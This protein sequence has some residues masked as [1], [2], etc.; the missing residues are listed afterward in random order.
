MAYVLADT[1]PL[2]IPGA[3]NYIIAS[4]ARIRWEEQL[5]KYVF[6]RQCGLLPKRSSLANPLD[7]NTSS[8]IASLQQDSGACFLM[9]FASAFFSISEEFMVAALLSIGMPAQATCAIYALCADSN[10]KVKHGAG[11]ATGFHVSRRET[12]LAVLAASL[13][14]IRRAAHGAHRAGVP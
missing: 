13:R 14:H 9:D 8:M 6:P 5:A 10:C 2:S 1:W 3:D 4:A 11:Q 12:G 7:V